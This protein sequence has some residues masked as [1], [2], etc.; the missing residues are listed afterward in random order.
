MVSCG[1][2]SDPEIEKSAKT[3]MKSAFYERF[4]DSKFVKV[5]NEEVMFSNDSLCIIHADYILKN[6]KLNL[7]FEG[8]MEYIYLISHNVA[9][10]NLT[11]TGMVSS[12]DDEGDKIYVSQE[13]YDKKKED[14][15]YRLL[16]YP[17]GLYYLASLSINSGGRQVGNTEWG[18]VRIPSITGT[19][20]W[21]LGN[22]V[23]DFGDRIGKHY[24][25]L[26]GA[27]TFSNSV[28]TNSKLTAFL[29][30]D[31]DGSFYFK[32][33][34]Y[35]DYVVREGE[36][37]VFKIKDAEGKI[38]DIEMYN[39]ESSGGTILRYDRKGEEMKQIFSREGEIAVSTSIGKYSRSSYRFKFDLTG[40]GEAMKVIAEE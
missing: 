33:Y 12:F 26:M 22:Y 36:F 38:H 4:E 9:Y 16:D 17:Q 29:Y 7:E 35:G 10:E 14:K 31:P 24:I 21:A 11:V 19:G 37:C 30:V 25:F 1:G 18:G 32:L 5:P 2:N 34:E 8:D 28:T 15:I 20:K 23:D 3:A 27:G 6:K 13:E 39:S 40:Y